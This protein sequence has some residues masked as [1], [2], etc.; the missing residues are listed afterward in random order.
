M[1]R[2]SPKSTIGE[3]EMDDIHNQAGS[4]VGPQ[5]LSAKDVAQF[6][7]RWL[8]LIILAPLA[9]SGSSLAFSLL[10]A[11]TYEA[12][13]TVLVGQQQA[14]GH[15]SP[16]RVEELQALIPSALE[17]ITTRPVAEEAT[18]GLDLAIDP[19]AVLENLSAE[20]TIESGQLI[21]VS[22]TD[23]DARRSEQLVNAVGEVA[24][25]R[26]SRLPISAHDIKATV[27]EAARVP[28]TRKEPDLLRNAILAGG[29]GTMI[30][31]G[32]AF[33]GEVVDP[34]GKPRDKT[35]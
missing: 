35:E 1:V 28:S 4:P 32:L 13:A 3:G 12:S 2:S 17:I 14:Q 33:V 6:L 34:S 15:S 18:S 11:P 26:I 5:P 10:Q 7:R 24:S 8:W 29:L 30:G 22:Y 21:E 19:E 25:E 31:F 9:I 20:Q 27:V 16:A 23:T